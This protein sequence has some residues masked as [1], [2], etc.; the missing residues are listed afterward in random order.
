MVKWE[1]LAVPKEF[2]GLG[3]IDTRAMNTSL[4][5]KWIFK[6]ESGEKSLALEVLRKK[7][8]ND[9][10]SARV[11]KRVAL[12]FGRGLA[13]PENGMK[14]GLNGYLAMVGRLGFGMMFG[15]EIVHS[16]LC[17]QDCLESAGIWIGQWLMLKR[18]TGSLILGGGLEMRLWLSGMIS[19]KL[20][21]I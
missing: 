15:W 7:Y 5:A 17:S 10:S 3:F 9:K 12:N 14:G 1:A 2:G 11:S 21:M 6:L 19:K 8:L 13:K 4:L 18:W 20:L 16:R